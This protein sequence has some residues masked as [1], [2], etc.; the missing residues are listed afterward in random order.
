VEPFIKVGL[1][2][3][4]VVLTGTLESIRHILAFEGQFSK[5]M[6]VFSVDW[7]PP[8]QLETSVTHHAD[9]E[10]GAPP[11]ITSGIEHWQVSEVHITLL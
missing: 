2:F 4:F 11:N 3:L 10:F 1:S 5:L 9:Q 6:D 8:I 7:A